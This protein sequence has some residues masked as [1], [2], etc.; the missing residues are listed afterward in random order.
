MKDSWSKVSGKLGFQRQ[1]DDKKL[2]K[3]IF[4]VLLAVPVTLILTSC[5]TPD[6]RQ[7]ATAQDCIDSARTAADADRCYASVEGLESEKAY[8]VRCSASYIAQGFT[9]ERFANAFQKLKDNS[10]SGQDP[11]ATTMAYLI[12]TK[13]TAPHTIDNT[14]DNC[15]KSGVRSMVRLV[16][17][18][19]LATFVAK[20]GLGSIPAGADPMDPSFDPAQ[21][22]TAI[23][24]LANSNDPQSKETVGTI[25]VQAQ[26]A[27]C[28]P[29]SSFET[30][31]IC[32]KLNSA[33]A[34]NPGDMAAIGQA[35]LGLLQ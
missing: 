31:E 18:S 23:S 20:A 30:S 32:T 4:K 35:L 11:M 5:E 28:N 27:Y 24:N 14:V 34:G 29:G 3:S 2:M 21:I 8:L 26:D 19:K 13:D 7:I 9:G 12:F 6:D 22:S 16:T 10:S 17:M 33:I 15:A 25:A 1:V